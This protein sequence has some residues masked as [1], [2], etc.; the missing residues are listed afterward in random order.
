MPGMNG[1]EL[2]HAARAAHPEMKTILFSGNV[3]E[4]ILEQFSVKPDHFIRKPFYPQ[5]LLDLVQNVL[6]R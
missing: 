3:Q 4:D 5:T 2:I 1:M 6:A